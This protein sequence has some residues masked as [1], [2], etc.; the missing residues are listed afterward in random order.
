MFEALL[1]QLHAD[2]VR[3]PQATAP[4]AAGIYAV[5]LVQPDPSFPRVDASAPLY[6]GRSGNLKRRAMSQHLKPRASGSSTLR[7]S[8]GAMLRGGLNL[9]AI[10]RGTGKSAKDCTNYRFDDDGE[11][12]LSQWMDEHLAIAFH[13]TARYAELEREVVGTIRPPLNIEHCSGPAVE[14]LRSLRAR[15][16]AGARVVQAMCLT[17]ASSRTP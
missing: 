10:P 16:A 2:R 14:E 8:L 9:T 3:L 4:D 5:Y 13:R 11:S 7:R 1:K 12:R 15:C 17:S 6:I